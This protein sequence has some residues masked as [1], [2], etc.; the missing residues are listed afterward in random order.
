MAQVLV[1]NLDPELL[2]K[3]KERAREHGRSLQ[4]EM[5]EIFESAARFTLTDARKAAARIRRRLSAKKQTDS[6][7]LIARDRAR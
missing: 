3:L 7:E 5:K 6:A 1:R 2:E 4:A